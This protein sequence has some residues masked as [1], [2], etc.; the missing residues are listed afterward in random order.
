M[1]HLICIT[2]AN[3]RL[4]KFASEITFH[5]RFMFPHI[6]LCLNNFHR[7][8]QSHQLG[9]QL[10]RLLHLNILLHRSRRPLHQLLR[11]L[12]PQGGHCPHLLNH[13]NLT[14]RLE[15]RQLQ[16]E[17]C[18][19]LLDFFRRL[20]VPALGAAP[21]STTT[22]HSFPFRVG[23]RDAQ[24][25]V[26]QFR[27][28]VDFDHVEP[29]YFLEER[30]DLRGGEGGEVFRVWFVG[31]RGSGGSSTLVILC[32]GCEVKMTMLIFCSHVRVG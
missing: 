27:E 25:F 13:L 28:E 19:L 21:S 6:Q 16:I 10:L 7:G 24:F 4:I 32:D 30:L 15:S 3:V 2:L 11:L 9:F 26:D 14:L 31:S 20:V 12:Q 22:G 5:I 18:L 8:P 1:A 17:R 29:D 23:Y